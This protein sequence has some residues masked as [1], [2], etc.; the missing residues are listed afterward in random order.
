M[1]AY[2]YDDNGNLTEKT[3]AR[4]VVTSYVYDALNRM[5]TRSYTNDP[6][7]RPAVTYTYDAAGVAFSKGRLTLVSSSVSTT[8]YTEYDALL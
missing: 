4:G 7:G 6:T 1:V 2:Q 8:G 3:E 5:T